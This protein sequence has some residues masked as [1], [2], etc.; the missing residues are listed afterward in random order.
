MKLDKAEIKRVRQHMLGTNQHRLIENCGTFF[1]CWLDED[2]YKPPPDL[3]GKKR[4]KWFDRRAIYRYSIDSIDQ[5]TGNVRFW[6]PQCAGRVRS[7]LK[8]RN[9]KVKTNNNAPFIARTDDTEYC[10][11]GRVTVPIKYLDRF[12]PI[13]F[14]TTASKKSYNRRNQIENLNGILRDKGG[15]DDKWC[16]ALGDGARF[17]GS[18]MMGVAF[19]LGETKKAWQDSNSNDPEALDSNETESNSDQPNTHETPPEQTDTGQSDNQS[20]DGPH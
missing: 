14:G 15:L 6:C 16:R 4:R 5:R 7:N 1:P 18:V 11:P 17:V 9:P 13:P 20:R 12:N 3:K 10:C 2:L 19:L 8:T